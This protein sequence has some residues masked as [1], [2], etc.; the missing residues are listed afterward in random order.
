MK[1]QH[2][3]QQLCTMPVLM[4]PLRFVDADFAHKIHAPHL[5]SF[6]YR[7]HIY[8]RNTAGNNIF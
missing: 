4:L 5:Q 2:K 1:F 8:L 3:F 7:F 6:Q